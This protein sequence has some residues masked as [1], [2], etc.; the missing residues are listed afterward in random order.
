MVEGTLIRSKRLS[1]SPLAL[2]DVDDFFAITNDEGVVLNTAT[3]P[4][5]YLK[6]DTRERITKALKTDA[7][8]QCFLGI[9]LGNELCGAISYMQMPQTPDRYEIGYHIARHYWG[10]GF[11]SEAVQAFLDYMHRT[12]GTDITI[13]AGHWADNPASGKVLRKCGFVKIGES[14][15]FS[16]A[17]NAMTPSIDYEWRHPQP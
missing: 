6:S 3:L 8:Q 5:P 16:K 7:V 13:G 10:Q 12:L 11:A 14:E 4:W 17:R 9:R 1:L 15:V 2:D